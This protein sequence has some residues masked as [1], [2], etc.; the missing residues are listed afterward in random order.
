MCLYAHLPHGGTDHCS[1]SLDHKYNLTSIETMLQ[2]SQ[3]IFPLAFPEEEQKKKQ[4]I[5]P[6]LI[7]D[8]CTESLEQKTHGCL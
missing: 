8:K 7:Q 2:N 4:E 3:L 5:S 6:P 1:T